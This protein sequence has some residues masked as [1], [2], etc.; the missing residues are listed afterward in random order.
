M[1]PTP[2]PAAPGFEV[3][4]ACNV[5]GFVLLIITTASLWRLGVA[6][7]GWLGRIGLGAAL[8]AL[9]GFAA[10]E[11]ATRYVA[12]IGEK[13]HPI[14]VPLLALGM[15]AAGIATFRAGVWRGWV[16]VTPLL[17]G[18]VPLAVEL[19]LVLL[20]GPIGVVIA[21]IWGCWVLLGAALGFTSIADR[22]RAARAATDRESR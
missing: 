6:G 14:T 15:T 12:T 21:L 16:R 4:N 2:D 1:F 17:C 7:R 18:I 13:G 10:I 3:F 20:F 19:P 8:M 22:R 9:T 11:F 5:I